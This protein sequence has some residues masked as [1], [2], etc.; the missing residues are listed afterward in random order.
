VRAHNTATDSEN[1][2]HD[3][4]VATAYGFRGGLVPGVAVY[5]YMIPPILECFGLSW[6]ERGAMSLRLV[7]PCYEGETVVTR[8]NGSAATAENE[9]G[10]LYASGQVS[11]D[12]SAGGIP[13]SFQFHE[14]PHIDQRPIACAETVVAG[15]RLGSVCEKLEAADEA[16]IPERLLHLANEILTR[17]F[18]MGPWI[19]A[20]SEIR[21]HRRPAAGDEI[22][23]SGEIKECFERKG[24][25]F[26]V[27]AIAMSMAESHPVASVRHTFIYDLG[28]KPE[29]PET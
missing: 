20:A 19:H 23:A 1:K 27:A 4:R 2:I 9:S 22:T 28:T 10:S 26:A 6:L 29:V 5:G 21:H 15:K 7:A 13:F 18:R 14:P 16:A 25:R 3:D 11:M 8:C 24:R 12:Q 17:N